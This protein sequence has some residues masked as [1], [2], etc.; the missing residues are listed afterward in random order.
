MISVGSVSILARNNGH[1]MHGWLGMVDR[2]G[3]VWFRQF[4]MFDVGSGMFALRCHGF[5]DG[6]DATSQA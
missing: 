3:L 6:C 5:D 1:M 2:A 4:M